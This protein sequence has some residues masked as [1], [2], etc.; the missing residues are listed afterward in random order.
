MTHQHVSRKR[1]KAFSAALFL[2]GLASLTFLGWWP[3]IMLVI[4][5]S[6]ALRQFLLGHHYDMVVTLLVFGGGFLTLAFSIPWN[7]F[8]P[9]IFV[10][11]AIYILVREFFEVRTETE[12][13]QEEDAQQEIEEE[14]K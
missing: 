3:G 4:G 12:Q 14:K 6:L 10:L 7:F 9:T 2:V 13:E 11:G 1:A 5:L 8:L